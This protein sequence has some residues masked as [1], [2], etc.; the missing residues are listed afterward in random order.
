MDLALIIY[1][2]GLF[3]VANLLSFLAAIVCVGVA[4]IALMV[5]GDSCSDDPP[6]WFKPKS[7]LRA[8]TAFIILFALL[9][10]ENTAY[11]MLAAYGVQQV[12]QSETV[13]RLA[14]KSIELL[15][16]TIDAHLQQLKDSNKE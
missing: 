4:A 1:L 12:A 5:W 11:K 10:T 3:K 2:I 7:L 8:F 13:G 15:E 9:P 16:Q 6:S 14:P